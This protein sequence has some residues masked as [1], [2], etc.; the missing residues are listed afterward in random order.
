MTESWENAEERRKVE[1]K[2]EKV[3]GN[4]KE[5][6]FNKE[7][8]ACENEGKEERR[9]IGK[10]RKWRVNGREEMG[11]ETDEKGGESEAGRKWVEER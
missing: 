2:R 6:M 11:K 5:V 7:M 8:W 1:G 10:G 3:R 9:D 4:K